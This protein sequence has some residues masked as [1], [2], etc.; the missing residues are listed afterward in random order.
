MLLLLF[1]FLCLGFRW[2]SGS[3]AS[4]FDIRNDGSE[5]WKDFESDHFMEQPQQV[6]CE[7]ITPWEW[8]PLFCV[9]CLM[10]PTLILLIK[11]FKS[12]SQACLWEF[13]GSPQFPAG[14][15]SNCY[16]VDN[17]DNF[18]TPP[19]LPGN[20]R[21]HSSHSKESPKNSIRH[22]ILPGHVD[23]LGDR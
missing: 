8:K 23:A 15:Q 20:H 5:M 16:S 3:L 9:F 12:K 4:I 11:R 1:L 13:P 19:L 6:L 17:L 22:L 14:A 21:D 2:N 7:R 10:K 18:F